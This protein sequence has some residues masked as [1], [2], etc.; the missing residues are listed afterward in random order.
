M[1]SLSNSSMV[2]KNRCRHQKRKLKSF[3]MGGR[4][5]PGIAEKAH[6]ATSQKNY[7]QNKTTLQ[8]NVE[9]N[10]VSEVLM[11]AGGKRSCLKLS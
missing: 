6:S 9:A 5:S 1:Y 4:Y 11:N 8:S 2:F 7:A 10:S 3:L